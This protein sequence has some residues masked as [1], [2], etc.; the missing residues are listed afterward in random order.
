MFICVLLCD[1]LAHFSIV[2]F[3]PI[4]SKGLFIDKNYLP[5]YIFRI[6]TFLLHVTNKYFLL[7]VYFAFNFIVIVL[8]EINVF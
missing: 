6:V 5:L 4:H 2:V 3:F 1:I 8:F 7:R